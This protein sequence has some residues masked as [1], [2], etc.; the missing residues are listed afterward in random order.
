MPKKQG[1]TNRAE[2]RVEVKEQNFGDLL[3]EGLREIRAI[4]R[5]ELEP[6][7]R[8]RRAITAR[9]V[10]VEPPHRYGAE[11][12]QSIRRQ[13]GLS[14]HVFAQVLGASTE[15]VKAWEQGKR[16]PD[17]MALVLLE[18]AERHPE[19]LLER[20]REKTPPAPSRS[21]RVKHVIEETE[22]RRDFTGPE[23]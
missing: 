10:E 21:K 3:I 16:E 4:Q 22:A 2:D 13:L 20:V 19:A 1:V 12:I 11:K 9:Q 18:I 5:G 17:G 6:A 15:T 8:V 7:S 14:Q 23:G